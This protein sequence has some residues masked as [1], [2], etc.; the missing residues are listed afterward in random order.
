MGRFPRGSD[1]GS[2]H[3]LKVEQCFA[4]SDGNG[5][6]T[7]LLQDHCSLAGRVGQELLK[8]CPVQLP[9][10]S[11]FLVA[12]H[13]VGK[14]SPGFQKKICNETLKTL[15]PGLAAVSSE[16]FAWVSKHAEIGEAAFKDRYPGVVRWGEVV[17][18][19]HGSRTHPKSG[20]CGD[21]GGTGW[22]AERERLFEMLEARFGSPPQLPPSPEQF[23]LV[24][25]LTCVSDWIASNEE[26][27]ADPS[28]AD[29]AGIRSALDEAGW[30]TPVVRQGLGFEDV[31]PFPP[32]PMQEEFVRCVDRRGVYVL[33]APMGLGKTEAALFAAYKLME[34]GENNGIYFGLP[35]RLTSNRIHT[36]VEEFLDKVLENPGY[37][38]LLHGQAWMDLESNAKEF[39]AGMAWFSPRKRALLAPFGVGTIDQALMSV[40]NVKHAFVRTFGLAGKVVILDEVHSYDAY[41]GTLLNLLVEE[42]LKIGCSVIILSATLT[43]RRRNEFTKRMDA[44]P[45]YPL[46]ST[47]HM[48]VAPEPPQNRAVRIRFGDQEELIGKAVAKAEDGAC[49]L[50]IA[51][52]VAEAQAIYCRINRAKNQGAFAT[53]LLHSRFPAW[54]RAELE[55]EWMGALGKGGESRP[56]GCVLMATQ[57]V[58]QSVDID[59]DLLVTELA[60]TDMLLQR[61]GRLW[62]HGRECRPCDQAETWIYD[63]TEVARKVY[64]PYVLWC[65]EQVWR[66]RTQ[67]VLPSEIRDLLEAT[68]ADREELPEE[69]EPLK[70]ELEAK[71]KKLSHMALGVTSLFAGDDDEDNAP[72]RYST[73]PTIQVLIVE[74]IDDLDLSAE[75]ELLSGEQ[76]SLQAGVRDFK[77]AVA[78]HQNL[79]SMPRF[80][81]ELKTPRWL[82]SLVFGEVLVLRLE[83]GRLFMLDGTEVPRGYHPDKGV[84]NRDDLPR[85]EQEES[86]DESD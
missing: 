1:S 3:V 35:T 12:S 26:I 76:L 68:Y 69:I 64:A 56:Q 79:V 86:D 54:H 72:T 48:S 71:R 4:K 37:V 5:E 61:I 15:C 11:P 36:R 63:A 16:G 17:G 51:N 27:F 24:A 44:P 29:E 66:S 46:I 25:G 28:S 77:Q 83:D 49:V 58:E 80:V 7:V 18:I 9:A 41:T 10:E 19:H 34:S 47:T 42:L 70:A 22:A 73:L 8:Q 40:L 53:G 75:V 81:K 67:V 60:P 38:K 78:I 52:T 20:N 62:R 85:K 43:A 32:H 55:A 13:D 33:E 84:F 23:K 82:Q 30:R 45:D 57:V 59:A 50:W 2:A 31:F 6:G 39:R 65:T 74:E 14:A 21:Y